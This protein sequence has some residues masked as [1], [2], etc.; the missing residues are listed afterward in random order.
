MR[1]SLRQIQSFFLTTLFSFTLPLLLIGGLLG[2]LT[3]GHWLPGVTTLSYQALDFVVDF[4]AAFGDGHALNGSFVIAAA[5]GF[6][7][8]LFYACTPYHSHDSI[9]CP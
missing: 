7:G 5:F 9:G 3:V 1:F 8:G 4:L 2:S 6:V